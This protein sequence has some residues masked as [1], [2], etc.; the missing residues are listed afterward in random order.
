MKEQGKYS[1]KLNVIAEK[2]V[3][4]YFYWNKAKE[5]MFDISQELRF[6]GSFRFLTSS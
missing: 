5:K 1:G 2:C 6:L 3:I 4:Y